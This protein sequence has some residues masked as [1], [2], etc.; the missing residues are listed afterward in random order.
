VKNRFNPKDTSTEFL[1]VANFPAGNNSLLEYTSAVYVERLNRIYLVGGSIRQNTTIIHEYQEKIWYIDISSLQVSCRNRTDGNYINPSECS[2]FVNCR[3]GNAS[4][5]TCPEPLLFDPLERKCNF[6]DLTDCT[7]TCE[8]KEGFFP[9]PN[10]CS[11]FIGCHGGSPDIVVYECPE[12]FL[13]DPV[14]VECGWPDLVQC[15][16]S[17]FKTT[18]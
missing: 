15:E 14:T 12:P 9:H 1:P 5:F 16:S 13:F 2:S 4:V 17:L 3:A 6:P 7:L 11:L 8:G 10:N 18:N